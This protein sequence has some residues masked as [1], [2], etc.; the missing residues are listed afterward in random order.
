MDEDEED[1]EKDLEGQ[2]DPAD[3]EMVERDEI[4]HESD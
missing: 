4:A 1:E 2:L 3:V